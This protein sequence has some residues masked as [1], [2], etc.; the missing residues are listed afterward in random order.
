VPTS[1]SSLTMVPRVCHVGSSKDAVRRS[2]PKARST[3]GTRTS[4]SSV[5]GGHFSSSSGR[6]LQP[7][8]PA[9]MPEHPSANSEGQPEGDCV[10]FVRNAIR[11]SGGSEEKVNDA[12]AVGPAL[13]TPELPGRPTAASRFGSQS[14]EVLR[15]PALMTAIRRAHPGSES[16][17]HWRHSRRDRRSP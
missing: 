9:K 16:A 4:R 13:I 17:R 3:A 12:L 14:G 11:C 8:L 15:C 2:L 10:R 6:R 5:V 1:F 7:P